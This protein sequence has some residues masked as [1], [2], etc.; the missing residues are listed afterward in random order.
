MASWHRHW[1]QYRRDVASRQLALPS[2]L[3]DWLSAFV[4]P[5]APDAALPLDVANSST[6][7]QTRTHLNARPVSSDHDNS[8]SQTYRRRLAA[9]GGG[10]ARAARF[11]STGR[12]T[13]D[14][15]ENR[16]GRAKYA[17]ARKFNADSARISGQRLCIY[18]VGHRLFFGIWTPF[19]KVVYNFD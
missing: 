2:V 4:L 16:R 17:S 10:S 9:S 7:T 18:L 5:A 6:T 14:R 15:P 12:G 13:R 19:L 11:A 1:S 3:R 8:D